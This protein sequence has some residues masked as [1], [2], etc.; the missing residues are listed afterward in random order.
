MNR[1]KQHILQ[2]EC[3]CCFYLG[4]DIFIRA[5]CLIDNRCLVYFLIS[6][7]LLSPHVQCILIF[8]FHLNNFYVGSTYSYSLLITMRRERDTLKNGSILVACDANFFV[9]SGRLLLT[10]RCT[11]RVERINTMHFKE[12]RTERAASS[13]DSYVTYAAALLVLLPVISALAVV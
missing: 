4:S 12:D 7:V 13:L 2:L 8:D 9:Q 5:N 1:F 3:N 11:Q 10:C 6:C